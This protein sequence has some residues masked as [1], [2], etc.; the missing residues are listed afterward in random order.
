MQ[1]P[2]NRRRNGRAYQVG[3]AVSATA[4]HG[5]SSAGFSPRQP[6]RSAPNMTKP[7]AYFEARE[8]INIGF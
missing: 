6:Q 2:M 1:I 3:K 7:Q 5:V 8:F 4:K